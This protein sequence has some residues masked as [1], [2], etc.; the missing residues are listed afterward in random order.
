MQPSEIHKRNELAVAKE[1]LKSGT[2]EEKA[3]AKV[4]I[5]ELESQLGIKHKIERAQMA[6]DE[7]P[8]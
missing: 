5:K 8:E 3:N 1:L 4:Y 6:T 2:P 7:Q